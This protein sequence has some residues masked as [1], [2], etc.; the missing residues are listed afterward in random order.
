MRVRNT[1]SRGERTIAALD[2]GSSKVA[3][4]I[5]VS[6]GES[7]PRVIGTGQRAC[8]GLR[9]GLVADLERTESAIRAAMEQAERNAGVTVENVVVSVS[10]GG[11]DSE[12]VSVE[13]DI[14]GQRIERGDIDHVLS[15][16]R[17]QL[18]AGGR[19]ILHA[20]PAL[21]TLDETTRVMNPLG[22]HADRLGVDIHIITADTPP[23]RN[24]DQCVR[25]AD[26]GV[27]TIVASPIA[28]GLA[29]LAPEERE[30]GVALVEI[31]AGVT[32][33][34]VHVRGM[35][36]GL[37]VIPMGSEDIT[38]D[39]ASTFSTRRIHAERLKTLYGSA[40]TSPRDNHDMIEILPISED[41]DV[42]PTRV[43]RAQIVAVIR[44]RLDMLFSDVGERLNEMGFKGPRGRQMVLTGGGAELKCIADFAQG[45]LGRH[46][47]VG[48]PRGLV[49]LPE[50]QVGSAFSTLAG[51][52]LYGAEDREDLWAGSVRDGGQMRMSRSPWG[53]MIEVLRS[54][55]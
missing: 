8:T 24:L 33:V 35:L 7:P 26:L 19:T 25:T 23:V 27:Q 41:D 47:R 9:Q 4:L 49:G 18:D 1:G 38:A 12:I 13:V 52:A 28:A 51:L 14:G 39:I 50:A 31:G 44:D 2:I 34:A 40:T 21:Y 22:L 42:E 29:C 10:A 17:A 3:A 48:R 37:S 6:D 16:G 20:Q 36:V 32:N 5:A 45:L 54:N 46:C 30:L 11:L 43:P 53:R 15:E 55:L